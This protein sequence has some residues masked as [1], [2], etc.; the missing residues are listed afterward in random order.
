M[1]YFASKDSI[2]SSPC[3]GLGEIAGAVPV[4]SPPSRLVINGRRLIE[5]G[6]KAAATAT[7]FNFFRNSLRLILL[8]ISEASVRY[9]YITYSMVIIP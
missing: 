1:P 8:V 7:S 3:S 4:A 9:R 6:T 5:G 2:V